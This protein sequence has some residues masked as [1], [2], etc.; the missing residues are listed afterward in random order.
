MRRFLL[1]FSTYLW[2]LS[3]PST[4]AL[5][6][7]DCH[8]AVVAKFGD[9]IHGLSGSTSQPTQIRI[10]FKPGVPGATQTN[11]RN[12][13]NAYDFNLSKPNPK[14]FMIDV[15]SDATVAAGV[16]DGMELFAVLYDRGWKQIAMDKW[17]RFVASGPA[18]QVTKVRTH[19]ANNGITLP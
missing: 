7:A 14:Q 12:F 9:V 15:L 18:A 4:C 19:A 17:A 13:V 3:M 16:K 10:D 6:I 8:D 11:V 2:L 1:F 5:E